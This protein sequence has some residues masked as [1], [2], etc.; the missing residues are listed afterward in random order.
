MSRLLGREPEE[1][2]PLGEGEFSA[3]LVLPSS[4]AALIAARLRAL[5]LDGK[6]LEV[7]AKPALGRSAVRAGRLAEA[8]ER[9]VTTPG[10]LRA[11][12]RATGEGRYSLTPEALALRLGELAAGRSVVEACVGSGGNSVGFARAG[13]RV[14]GF[15]VDAERLAEARHNT[16]VYGVAQRVELVQADAL[17][18]VPGERAEILFVDPPWGGETYDKRYSD[19]T[20]FPLLDQLLAQDLSGYREVW[21]KVPNSFRVASV[22][23]ARAEAWFG[24]AAG[25]RHRIKFVLLRREQR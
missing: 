15:D 9:R 4:E 20:T 25:D 16:Q 11:G 17:S 23:G 8:R 7:M 2:A 1:L 21:I 19:R 24:E 18:A 6:P 14:R 12:A 3:T 10:F 22:D 13:C 5:G